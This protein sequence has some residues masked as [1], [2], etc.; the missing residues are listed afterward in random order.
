MARR[1]VGRAS[2]YEQH[3]NTYHESKE[4]KRIQTMG[5]C[6]FQGVCLA[7]EWHRA[8]LYVCRERDSEPMQGRVG[9]MILAA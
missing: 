9:P 2:H 6:V 4:N 8:D 7:I 3:T 1:I 5:P